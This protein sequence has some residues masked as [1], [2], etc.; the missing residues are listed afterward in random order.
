MRRITNAVDPERMQELLERVPR[1]CVAFNNAGIVELVPVE[2][3]FQA[4]R[5][6][7]GMSEGGSEPAPGPGEPMKLLIDEGM[8]YFD[9]RG[10]WIRGRALFSEE[11][12]EGG[13]AELSWLQLV[14]EKFVAWDFGAMRELRKQ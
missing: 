10:I 2:F 11:R 3:R 1:A 12:P 14:P 4:G 7:I 13:S 6:W 9:M 8:Y 5:Y